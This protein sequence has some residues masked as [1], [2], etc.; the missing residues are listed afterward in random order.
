MRA[1]LK[2]ELSPGEATKT[3]SETVHGGEQKE[4]ERE[5]A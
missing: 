3:R 1:G 2:R 4:R 5:D